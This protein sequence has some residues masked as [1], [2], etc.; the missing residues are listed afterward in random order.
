MKFIVDRNQLLKHIKDLGTKEGPKTRLNEVIRFT[1][2]SPRQLLMTIVGPLKGAMFSVTMPASIHIAGDM[3]VQRSQFQAALELAEPGETCIQVENG[4]LSIGADVRVQLHEA[5]LDGYCF[6]LHDP[7]T[8]LV[9]PITTF[10]AMVA[11][12]KHA[13]CKDETKYNLNHVYFHDE[14]GGAIAAATDG[15]RLA[16][17]GRWMASVPTG[18]VLFPDSMLPLMAL[19]KDS[20]A[21][22]VAGYWSPPPPPVEYETVYKFK[23]QS[24]NKTTYLADTFLKH[25]EQQERTRN[26]YTENAKDYQSKG[27]ANEAAHRLEQAAR[28]DTYLAY[29]RTIQPEQREKHFSIPTWFVVQCGDYHFTK[30]HDGGDFPEYTK[31]FWGG[32]PTFSFRANAGDLRTT[33]SRIPKKKGMTPVSLTFTATGCTVSSSCVDT[34]LTFKKALPVEAPVFPAEC[35]LLQTRINLPY[36]LDILKVVN[37]ELVLNFTANPHGVTENLHPVKFLDGD[38]EERLFVVMPM[39]L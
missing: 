36:L 28:I 29:L 20:E 16:R 6:D 1:A 17:T 19:V 22:V 4:N 7:T 8:P 38:R 33:L 9:L 12:V 10:R 11:D 21:V 25:V 13:V 24:D 31:A 23:D 30:Q 26:S 32:D 27:K 34:G 37:R 2:A 3:R 5:E 15:H 39:R 35:S 18:G 14:G